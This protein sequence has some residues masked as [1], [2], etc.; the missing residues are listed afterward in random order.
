MKRKQKEF[1][2]AVRLR[3]QGYSLREISEKLKISKGTA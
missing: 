3:R 1:E 2:K